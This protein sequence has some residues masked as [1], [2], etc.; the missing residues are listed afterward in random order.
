MLKINNLFR[1]ERTYNMYIKYLTLTSL[2]LGGKVQKLEGR[3][4]VNRDN[5]L[6]SSRY[7]LSQSV[8]DRCVIDV[9]GD[10]FVLSLD[11]LFSDRIWFVTI[12]LGQDLLLFIC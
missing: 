3:D 11:F 5:K 6:D 12:G 7:R 8:Y 1:R 9:L 4:P 2:E 10:L